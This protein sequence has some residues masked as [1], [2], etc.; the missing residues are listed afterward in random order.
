MNL[1]QEIRNK[2]DFENYMIDFFK[3]R[4]ELKFGY[5]DGYYWEEWYVRL[6]NNQTILIVEFSIGS[7]SGWIENNDHVTSMSLE[8]FRMLLLNK[9]FEDES[10]NLV[11]L[12]EEVTKELQRSE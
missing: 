12:I 10:V 11:N 3:E 4:E 5:N 8:E 2:F 1:K 9:K 6:N 7:G